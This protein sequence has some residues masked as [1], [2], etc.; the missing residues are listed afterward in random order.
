MKPLRVTAAA[1]TA[2]LFAAGCSGTSNDDQA[3]ANPAPTDG[4]LTVGLLEDIG[5]PRTRTSTTPTTAWP[6][7]STPTRAWSSTRTTSTP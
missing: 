4:T 3:Q 6:S 5:Q 7:C 2:V 1:L